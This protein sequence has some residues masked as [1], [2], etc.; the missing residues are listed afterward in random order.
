[1]AKILITGVMGTLGRPL[2][3][4]LEKRGHDVWGMDLQHQADQKYYR[5]DVGN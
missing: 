5:A 1:M 2:K 3:R 4:E